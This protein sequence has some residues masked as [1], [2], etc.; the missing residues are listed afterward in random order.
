MIEKGSSVDVDLGTSELVRFVEQALQ[1][2]EGKRQRKLVQ[3]LAQQTA[4]LL[5]FAQEAKSW[6]VNLCSRLQEEV[7]RART[8]LN[9]SPSPFYE[10]QKRAYQRALSFI[11]EEN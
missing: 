6:K 4:D 9:A 8:T 2:A 3:V 1:L 11:T 7:E 5:L 10:G